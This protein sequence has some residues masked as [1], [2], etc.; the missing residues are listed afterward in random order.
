MRNFF[1]FL[2]KMGIGKI[3]GF[4]SFYSSAYLIFIRTLGKNPSVEFHGQRIFLIPTDLGVSRRL[5]VFGD[6]VK[7]ITDYFSKTISPGMFVADIGANIGH[8]TLIAAE[9]VGKTGHVY[10]F[11][12]DPQ[13]FAILKKN[14]EANTHKN[15]SL[16]EMAV[17]NSNGYQTLYANNNF[18]SAGS[19]SRENLSSSLKS[20]GKDNERDENE[21]REYS[22]NS[23]RLDD[24]F[25]QHVGT[26]KLDVLKMNIQ[27]AEGL[28]LEGAKRLLQKS[29]PTIIMEFWPPGLE[30]FGTSAKNLL[31]WLGALGYYY[32]PINI[33]VHKN[34]FSAKDVIDIALERA[35]RKQDGLHLILQKQ[36]S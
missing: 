11:E 25:D 33:P 20:H 24:Y 1:R 5:L 3:P 22:V 21:Y 28:V 8:L 2:K 34:S 30:R 31:E 32:K 13:C 18:T 14:V 7:P 23:V 36:V 16:L 17:S 26:M 6:H 35:K 12:P 10:A 15:V 9:Q 27:G 29:S 19:L 4:L